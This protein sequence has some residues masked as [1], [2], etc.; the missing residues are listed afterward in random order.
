MHSYSELELLSD[1]LPRAIIQ[2]RQPS[3]RAAEQSAS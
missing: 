1:Y 3:A 2:H